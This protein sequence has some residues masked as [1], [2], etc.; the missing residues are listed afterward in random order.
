M[1]TLGSG[2]RCTWLGHCGAGSFHPTNIGEFAILKINCSLKGKSVYNNPTNGR[3]LGAL[4]RTISF[5]I[6]AAAFCS[7]QT[8]QKF[9]V[10][11]GGY[12]I[13]TGPDG[14]LWMTP[15]LLSPTLTMGRV[16]TSGAFTQIPLPAGYVP[17]GPVVNGPDG[18][19]WLQIVSNNDAAVIRMTTSGTF[20]E[21]AFDQTDG[22]NNMTVGPDGAI[23]LAEYDRIGRL[24]TSGVYTHFSTGTY[25]PQAIATGPDGNLWF[26]ALT[27]N[28]KSSAIGKMTPAGVVTTYPYSG[29]VNA[30]SVDGIAA[31][32]DGAI[33]FTIYA[34]ATGSPAIGKITTSGNISIYS[35]PNSNT[36]DFT[37]ASIAASPDAGLWFT[38]NG[39][40]GRI[41][42]SG[43]ATVYPLDTS[44]FALYAGGQ[45]LGITAGPDGAMWFPVLGNNGVA[46]A[47]LNGSSGITVSPLSLP[48]TTTVGQTPPSQSFQLS[49]ASGS[50]SYSLTVSYTTV[51]PVNWLQLST[52]GGTVTPGNPATVNA[53]IAAAASSFQ[54]GT[55]GATI[56]VNSSG[57]TVGITVTLSVNARAAP[58]PTTTVLTANPSSQNLGQ[59]VTLT[60]AVTPQTA[61]GFVNF[62]DG[63]TS[64]GAVSLSNGSAVLNTTS[65]TAGTH[66]ITAS[67]AG[68]PN[69]AASNSLPVS[70]TIMNPNQPTI[71]AGGIVNAASYATVNGAGAPVAPGSL[72]AIFT[73]ALMT[74]PASFTTETLPP[75]LSGVTLTIN[76]VT[77]PIVQVSPGGAYPFVSAQV[78]FEAMPTGANSATVP[79]V[80]SVNGVPSVPVQV[81]LVASAPG[82]FTIP[83]TGQGNAILVNLADYSVAAVAGAIPGI[84]THP[85]PRGQSAFFYVTGLGSL[86]PGVTS[87]SGQCTASNGLCSAA[88][89]PQVL[90]GGVPVPPDQV[91]FA[92]Q[93]PGFP[94]VDQINFTIPQ[95]APTGTVTLVVKSADGSVTSNAAM[96]AVQ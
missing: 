79:V 8:I 89:M 75:S 70:V 1:Y 30:Y 37:Q 61:T 84:T 95:G 46:R 39:A 11:Y 35:I 13:T 63:T 71:L 18:A 4:M 50:V 24:S 57:G 23:W 65:L 81:T 94:G 25:Y 59:Q 49:T 54:P 6:A 36:Y 77:A 66:T 21:Y 16:S 64:L 32:P 52:A 53:L 48:F 82:I 83:A 43:I 29:V 14:A 47:M 60:A 38:G 78:P 62:L 2:A 15:T 17:G 93:A 74:N 33:Y 27:P 45:G 26:T 31:G 67:Y 19:L 3:L 87:G 20:N 91:V 73:S 58:V 85:I 12:G 40:V 28:G 5:L 68:D 96:I 90:V 22:I 7:A 86:N 51:P 34:T 56:N 69:D 88:A 44:L 9:P 76:S 10:A 80:L 42:T 55:Y 92:G 41:T 72:I